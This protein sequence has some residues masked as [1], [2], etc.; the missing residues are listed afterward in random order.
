MDSGEKMDEETNDA[1]DRELS[2]LALKKT[3]V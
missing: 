1:F 3:S 2:N